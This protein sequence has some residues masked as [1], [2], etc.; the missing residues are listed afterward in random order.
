MNVITKSL[1]N[2]TGT[3]MY[4]HIELASSAGVINTPLNFTI[5]EEKTGFTPSLIPDLTAS[6]EQFNA[7]P[8]AF[9]SIGTI[10]S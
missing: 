9:W 5:F 8:N 1:P 2:Q 6:V 7:I 4:K 3:N 10:H